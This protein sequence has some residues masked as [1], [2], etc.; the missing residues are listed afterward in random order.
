MRLQ[1]VALVLA[2]QFSLMDSRAASHT[3]QSPR[4]QVHTNALI[5]E[6]SPYLLQHAH[7]PVDWRPWGQAAFDLA[8]RSDR[9]I[10]L[11]IGYST[12][13]WCHVMER[14]S[15]E[16]EATA[17]LLNS[18]FVCIKVDREERPD[19]DDVY[20]AATQVMSGS[21]GWPMSV[22]LEPTT[23]KP[24]YAGT[25]F[26]PEPAFGRPSFTQLLA[27]IDGAWR[28]RRDDVLTQS[29]QIAD[30]VRSHLAGHAAVRA[31]GQQD[32][33]RAIDA[34]MSIHDREHGGFGRAP[35]FPQPAYLQLLIGAA[36]DRDDVRLAI[37]KTLDRMALG[38]MYDQVG[39]GFHRYSVDERWIVPHFEKMLYDN[40]QLVSLYIEAFARTSDTFYADVARRTLAYV[41]REMTSDQGGFFSA[42]D[43]EVDAREGLNYLW[44]ADEFRAALREAGVN[45]ADISL[46]MKAHGV[47]GNPSFRDPHHPEDGWKYVLVLAGKPA[48]LAT[49]FGLD[50]EALRAKL[51]TWSEILLHR[52]GQR[53][54]PATDD[55]ILCGWNGLMIAGFADAARV[56]KEPRYSTAAGRAADFV[57]GH[58]RADDGSL[59]R[60]W[61][62]G[63]ARVPAFLEDYA[64]L[65][66]GLIALHRATG[67][68]RWLEECRGLVLQAEE[69]FAD[70]DRGAY[71]DTLA[72]Q[73]D[74]F[75]RTRSTHDGAVP[76]GNSIMLLSLLDLHELTN[77]ESYLNS[78]TLVLRGMSSSIAD[79]SLGPALATLAVHRMAAQWP[80][81]LPSDEVQAPMAISP[82]TVTPRET[83]VEIAPSR[84][85]TLVVDI[86]IQQG[87]HVVAHEPA[88]ERLVGLEFELVDGDG[89]TLTAAYPA[90]EVLDGEL[91]AYAGRVTISLRLE[92]VGIV[93]G[94]PAIL[95]TY[96]PCT[97]SECLRPVVMRLDV[98]LRSANPSGQ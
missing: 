98:E 44:T 92:Q 39:G 56:L 55:K 32:V 41:E 63:R 33:D 76:C 8:R 53:Q 11:S 18:N 36:W 91:R 75:V 68:A 77:D 71:F 28:S 62:D 37:L 70:N 50:P 72:D 86:E 81:R 43:A 42:Q 51:S 74:L 94:T 20:M 19:V 3:G 95:V 66:R 65:I 52:R 22:F 97:Q 17:A 21:G 6:T 35:K 89:L 15:F 26:P 47:A 29:E 73:S 80:Q 69:R 46:A 48:S 24:F 40:G 87:W 12:C 54:P 31:V 96:Q 82:V 13:Y 90:G 38:G 2:I 58:M 14:E 59:L 5:H 10:F 30:A 25:Y 23:L 9:P 49:Q 7:N 67:E 45:D 64:L 85:V 79:N 88:D 4:D 1:G 93:H 78:A 57:L 34:L 60:T 84:A 83:I 61:R 27:A 16:D